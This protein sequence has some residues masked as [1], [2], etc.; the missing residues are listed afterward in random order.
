MRLSL[1]LCFVA[2]L[3]IL[4]ASPISSECLALPQVPDSVV[5]EISYVRVKPGESLL[6]IARQFGIGYD[7][8]LRANPKLNRWIPDVGA[9]VTIPHL[10]ILPGST[11]RGIVLNIA[12]LRLYF[13][14]PHRQKE[15]AVVITYPVSIGRMDWRTPLGQTSVVEKIRDPSW[16]PPPSIRL[17]HAIEGEILPDIIAGGAEDNPL[18]LFAL[19][20]GF[21]SHLIHGVDERKAYGIG[22]RVTHGCV[23]MYPEDIEALFSM[24]SVGTPVLIIDEPVKL[25]QLGDKLFIEVHQPL[26]GEDDEAPIS[27]RVSPAKVLEQITQ[28][29]YR[30]GMGRTESSV[31]LDEEQIAEI[32]NRG[33]GIPTEITNSALVIFEKN[34]LQ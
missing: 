23:R 3:H 5:G 29:L 30:L 34:H 7:Q 22:M 19:R 2:L 15:S 26:D 16:R 25:G 8:I 4:F 32:T 9:L 31:Q 20:L 33:D 1:D 21:R 10:Y 27:S 28:R 24:V 17:E 14:P 18:G 6:D 11:R 13:Y 12:E